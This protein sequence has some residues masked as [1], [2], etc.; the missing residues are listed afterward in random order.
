MVG[1]RLMVTAAVAAL[2][3]SLHMGV[4]AAGLGAQSRVDGE[5]DAFN[6]LSWDGAEEE[7]GLTGFGRGRLD[8]R[9]DR[10]RN[11]QARLTI[12][13]LLTEAM[14]ADA[15]L[16]E[17]A[18]DGQ[19]PGDGVES[20]DAA[21]ESGGGES[22]GGVS[23]AGMAALPQAA[24]F[25][26]PRASL[27]FRFPVTE[28]YTVRVTTGRDRVSWGH[29]ALFNAADVIFGADGTGTADFRETGDNVRDETAWLTAVYFPLGDFAFFEPLVL[30]ALPDP[31]QP[32]ARNI[33][34]TRAG[35]RVSF[36]AG[37][38]TFE[39]GYLYDPADDRHDLVMSA[40]GLLG[41]DVYGGARL[42]VDPDI[43]RDNLD[44]RTT[45][46]VGAYHRESFT[47]DLSLDARLEALIRP[48]ASWDDEE[49]PDAEYA[50]TVYPEFVVS[51]SRTVSLIGRS[52]ISPIDRSARVSA[53]VNWNVFGGFDMLSFA[54]VEIGNKDSVF[55]W[56]REGAAALTSGVR[57]RF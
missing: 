20:G 43:D 42:A 11:I 13:A 50:V 26:V 41:I 24:F 5:I 1:N 53:G 28:E 51:P 34:E 31:G 33:E 3:F 23:A 57:Y 32:G 29:G 54:D 7:L 52:I 16:A 36:E 17:A 19:E 46:S 25:S 15:L 27:R 47:P 22:G 2:V 38:F 21:G 4:G 55:S 14:F 39:P 6:I 30:P 40:Q 10:D 49:N 35:G 48:G 45:F 56:E 8:L 12:D 37:R 9:S 18:G 44:E